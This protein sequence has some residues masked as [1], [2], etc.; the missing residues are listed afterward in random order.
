MLPSFRFDRMTQLEKLVV[1]LRELRDKGLRMDESKL[2]D[3]M[4]VYI[5][6]LVAEGSGEIC[7]R[8]I[9]AS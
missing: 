6:D 4:D 8:H 2:P 7:L 1:M 9:D 5:G 3:D